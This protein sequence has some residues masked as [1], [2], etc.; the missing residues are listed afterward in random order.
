M[1]A[2]RQELEQCMEQLPRQEAGS[3]GT[4][5]KQT[6]APAMFASKKSFMIVL[7]RRIVRLVAFGCIGLG[8]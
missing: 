1:T 3:G 2:W 5:C 7:Y 8:E 6:F 4:G